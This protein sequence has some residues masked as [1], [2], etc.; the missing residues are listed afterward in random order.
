MFVLDLPLRFEAEGYRG[1][2]SPIRR[3][4]RKY[5]LV[6]KI[7]AVRFVAEDMSVSRSTRCFFLSRVRYPAIEVLDDVTT[8]YNRLRFL[9]TRQKL[10]L[11]NDNDVYH[12]FALRFPHFVVSIPPLI[13]EV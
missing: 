6:S 9:Q 5:G 7:I 10:C 8:G 12:L 2:F 11:Q 1:G 3:I 13:V 4:R